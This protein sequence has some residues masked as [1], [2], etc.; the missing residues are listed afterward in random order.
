MKKIL[1]LLILTSCQSLILGNKNNKYSAVSGQNFMIATADKVA[2]EVGAEI[3]AKG[4]NAVDATIAAQMVLN[5][6]EP[7]SSGIGGGLFLLYFDAKTKKTLYFNGREISPSAVNEKIFLDKNGNVREFKDVVIGGLS[8]GTPGALYAL[9]SAHKKYGKLPWKDLFVPAI[10]IARD[11]FVLNKRIHSTLKK[12][13]G[14]NSLEGMRIYFEDGGEP[15]DVGTII[16]NPALAKTFETIASQGIK[17]FYEGKI[18]RKIVAAVRESKINPGYL[19]LADMSQYRDKTGDLLCAKYREK[20]K[21]C[22]MP[23]PSSGG[24]AVLEMLGILENFDLEKIKPSSLAAVHL[25]SEAARLAYSD[26]NEYVADIPNVPIQQMLDKQY[27]LERSK[28]ISLK[29]ALGK[30]EPGKFTKS[31]EPLNK[32]FEKP[33]TTHIAAVDKEG[34][35]VSMTSS[36]EYFFG[37]GLVVEGFM[38]NNE[39][40]DFSL[41]PKINGKKVANRVRPKKQPRS[42]MSPVFI[43]DSENNLLMAVGSAGGSRIAQYVLKTIVAHLDW[44]LDIQQSISLPNHLILDDVI[45]IE[46]GTKLQNLKSDLEK[47]G[48]KVVVK[49]ITSGLQGI[50]INKN[51]ITGGADPRRNSSAIGH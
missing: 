25:L 9:Q 44:G 50:A 23:L 1:I 26:R 12:E 45:E 38:L 48:H 33:S 41:T 47:M 29:K 6:V 3:L 5:V 28:L 10:K 7:E 36:I 14:L 20:Y 13:S 39:L 17:P 22:S 40:T 11:G 8:V 30:V 16:K 51:Q 43:F 4:G 49:E 27:L 37:S 32:E 21:V 15:K 35:A 2:S 18:A 34:N 42:T 31:A 19:S 46:A 24:I